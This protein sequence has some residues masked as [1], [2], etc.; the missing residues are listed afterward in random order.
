MNHRPGPFEIADQRMH[1]A[2]SKEKKVIKQKYLTRLKMR[3]FRCVVALAV[4][5]FGTTLFSQTLEIVYHR[6]GLSV[7]PDPT[8][9]PASPYSGAASR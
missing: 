4:L 3:A 9:S 7:V 5:L 2:H 6:S 1:N 8:F